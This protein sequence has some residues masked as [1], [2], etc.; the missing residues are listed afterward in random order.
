[1]AWFISNDFPI[2]LSS[3]YVPLPWYVISSETFTIKDRNQE[4]IYG[5]LDNDGII[6]LEGLA[7]LVIEN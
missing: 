2:G 4:I 5:I 6:D 7:Q 3:A 1:M